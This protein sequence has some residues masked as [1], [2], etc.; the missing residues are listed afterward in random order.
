MP[1]PHVLQCQQGIERVG[2]AHAVHV[3]RHA[4]HHGR[5]RRLGD[6]G[7]DPADG[8]DREAPARLAPSRP[9]KHAVLDNGRMA[10]IDASPPHS[11]P[12]AGEFNGLDRLRCRVRASAKFMAFFPW[13]DPTPHSLENVSGFQKTGRQPPQNR[14]RGQPGAG[15]GHRKTATPSTT[16]R[17]L[18]SNFWGGF[19]KIDGGGS[20]VPP[21]SDGS[22]ERLVAVRE[23]GCASLSNSV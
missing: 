17:P 11:P 10:E 7:G 2:G 9:A 20:R 13:H 18:R 14:R 21:Q 5:H 6:P 15:G 16:P 22:L 4:R 19:P 23:P 12:P 3:L 1:L 8:S